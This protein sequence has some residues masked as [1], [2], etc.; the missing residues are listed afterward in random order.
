MPKQGYSTPKLFSYEDD[1]DK[2]W[3][4]GFR[5]TCPTS[6]IRKPFQVRLGIN[7]YHTIK[8]RNAQGDGVVAITKKALK[9]GWNP[10]D[11]RIEDFLEK[12]APVQ[13]NELQKDREINLD[14][15]E[16]FSKLLFNDAL[17]AAYKIKE[18][19]LKERSLQAYFSIVKFAKQ[20]SITIG[21]D[22]H[23]IGSLKKMHYKKLL[24]Q[25]SK[26]RQAAYDKEGKGKIFTG[27]AY[28]KYKKNLSA[29][30]GELIE[31]DALEYNPCENLK[32]RPKI[33]TGINR[34]ATDLEAQII[35]RELLKRKPELCAFVRF[36]Y[37]TGMRPVEILA[38]K[39]SMIDWLNS[40]IRLSYVDGKTKIYREV[41]VP[42]YLLDWLHVRANRS[43]SD[44]YIFSNGL[45][46]GSHNLT[47]N[48]V[49]RMWN[50]IV[51]K[52]LGIPV[53]MYSFKGKGGDDKRDAGVDFGAV[54]VGWG[55][56]N[57]NTSK[58]YLEK[59]EQRLIK[60][61]IA[62]TPDF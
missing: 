34:H 11:E 26:D 61:L 46:P 22:K 17:A 10:F 28:N 31:L 6:Q 3:Y 48:R 58:I 27:S 9:D 16:D 50:K 35:K 57:P 37:V 59:E 56:T 49:T 60:Q 15:I 52:D 14:E 8:E 32:N 51:K 19:S 13:V 41:A 33:K 39:F 5:Y 23:Q 18:E 1:L 25:I 20:A 38:T 45:T 4:I 29:L 40:I 62:K 44:W 47:R 2:E 7:Y 53:S 12:S 24:L 36:E 30:L 42:S 54:M 21:L 43:E 55:H